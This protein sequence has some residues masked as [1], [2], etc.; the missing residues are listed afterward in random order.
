MAEWLSSRALL[1]RP[2]F[3]SSDGRH[4]PT[5]RSSGHAVAVSHIEELEGPTT[6]MHDHVLGGFGEEKKGEFKEQ[7]LIPLFRKGELKKLC[8]VTWETGLSPT[9]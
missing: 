7:R 8:Q 6:R 4:G 3:A 1:W 5:H 2:E 9:G